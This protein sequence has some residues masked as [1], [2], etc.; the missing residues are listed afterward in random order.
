VLESRSPI[1]KGDLPSGPEYVMMAYNL[2]GQ[3]TDPGPKADNQF[4]RDLAAKM[5]SLKGDKCM[6][7]ATGGFDWDSNGTVQDLTESDAYDLS[8]NSHDLQR[9][10]QS[11]ALHF[12]Y[13][14]K[15]GIHTVWYADGE[16]LAGWFNLSRSLGYGNV[17]LW[18]MG[19]NRPETLQM[20]GQL[21]QINNN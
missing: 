5:N 10:T 12:T 17:A 15:D 16:T 18:K 1:S 8:K 13:Q 19:G 21:Q 7:F 6:A 2:Y 9:D 4:I 11:G 14:A 20:L 3:G